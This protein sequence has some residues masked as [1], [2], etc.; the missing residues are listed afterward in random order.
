MAHFTFPFSI[1]PL[2]LLLPF[3]LRHANLFSS[4]SRDVVASH[5]QMQMKRWRTSSSDCVEEGVVGALGP[6]RRKT[7][8]RAL[9]SERS[10]RNKQPL[11]LT[12]SRSA[13][14]WKRDQALFLPL[15]VSWCTEPNTL[16]RFVGIRQKRKQKENFTFSEYLLPCY[17][18]LRCLSLTALRTSIGPSLRDS[19]E[20]VWD[21]G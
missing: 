20:E 16:L 21:L 13:D 9:H 8:S 3:L 4:F 6:R 5:S 1:S 18:T 19:S 11:C 7:G 10:V 17:N 14:V 15:S 2:L 12:L